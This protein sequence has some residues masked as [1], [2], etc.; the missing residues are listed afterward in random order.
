MYQSGTIFKVIKLL[1]VKIAW[2]YA[3]FLLEWLYEAFT[4]I[5]TSPG[6]QGEPPYDEFYELETL[7]V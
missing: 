7:I 4:E 1:L 5:S 2:L 6:D 3:L